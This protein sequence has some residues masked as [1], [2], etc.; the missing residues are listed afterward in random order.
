MSVTVRSSGSRADATGLF[1]TITPPQSAGTVATGRTGVLVGAVVGVV[2][3]GAV[4]D[5]AVVDGD[6]PRPCENVSEGTVVAHPPTLIRTKSA[7]LLRR[8]RHVYPT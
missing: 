8:T 7:T 6:A 1:A 3:I 4:V 2:G 5:G